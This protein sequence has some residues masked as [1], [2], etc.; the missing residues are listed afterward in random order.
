MPFGSHFFILTALLVLFVMFFWNLSIIKSFISVMLGIII[1]ALGEVLTI[2]FIANID[3][4]NMAQIE[5]NQ[6]YTF[7]LPLPQLLFSLL[8]VF[9]LIKYKLYLFDFHDMSSGGTFAANEKRVKNIMVLAAIM[10]LLIIVQVVFNLNLYNIYPHP[11]VK[12]LSISDIGIISSSATIGVF[13]VL[14]L[15][16]QQLFV[17]LRTESAYISQSAYIQTV[18]ELYTASRAEAHDRINHLQTLYGFVQ[19]GYLEET[20]A[21]LEELMGDEIVSQ[22]YFATG[23]PALSSLFFIKSGLAI[24]KGVHLEI[25]I[26][27]RIDNLEVPPHEINRILGNLINN[28]LDFAASLEKDQRIV[29]LFVS[30]DDKFYVFKVQNYGNLDPKVLG[31]IFEKNFTTRAG[32]HQGLGLYITKKL[33]DKHNGRIRVDNRDNLVEFTVELPRTTGRGDYYEFNSP[34]FGSP[35]GGRFYAGDR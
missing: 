30:G 29:N 4:I 34:E 3:N 21:Y 32:Q 28:A 31:K 12:S 35:P 19:L 14:V 2:S 20:R 1:L 6:L 23:H 8:L 22:K 33:V 17:L 24:S 25:S 5:S 15:L 10:F 18:D 26:D 9:M 7:L 11:I 16:I 27:T 13:I